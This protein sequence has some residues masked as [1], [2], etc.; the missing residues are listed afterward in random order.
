[1]IGVAIEAGI[2]HMFR[3]DAAR[4]VA[5]FDGV[6]DEETEVPLWKSVLL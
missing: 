2:L 6:R 5:A 1:M 3:W 4:V